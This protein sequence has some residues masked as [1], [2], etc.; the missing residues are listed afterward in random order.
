LGGED[1]GG[2]QTNLQGTMNRQVIEA[3]D[4]LKQF[5]ATEFERNIVAKHLG[6]KSADKDIRELI[7]VGK[8]IGF[9]FSEYFK[10]WQIRKLDMGLNL[11]PPDLLSMQSNA[12]GDSSGNSNQYS[13]YNYNKDDEMEIH[14]NQVRALWTLRFMEGN[15]LARLKTAVSIKKAENGMIKTVLN[16]GDFEKLRDKIKKEA[17]ALAKLRVMEAFLEAVWERS[18]LSH[19]NG[20]AHNLNRKKIAGLR[21]TLEKRF[22][23]TITPEEFKARI[24]EANHRMFDTAREELEKVMIMRKAN[25]SPV[26]EKKEMHLKMLMNRLKDESDIEADI[27]KSSAVGGAV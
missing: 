10:D 18:T 21:K 27:V 6:D 2:Y 4:D 8:K 26:L 19:L 16:F 11:M 20:P 22:G 14:I 9:N 15:M 25:E 12:Q 24:D 3:K 17:F 13:E 23:V 1:F 7:E 5:L